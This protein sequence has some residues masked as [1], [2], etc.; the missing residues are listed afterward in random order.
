MKGYQRAYPG[1]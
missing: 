1:S